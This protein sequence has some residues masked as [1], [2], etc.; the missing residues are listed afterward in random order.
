MPTRCGVTVQMTRSLVETTRL[1][2]IKEWI[3]SMEVQAMIQSQGEMHRLI[4]FTVELA[5][6]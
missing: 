4:T 3:P 1:K 2:V 6:I 5:M